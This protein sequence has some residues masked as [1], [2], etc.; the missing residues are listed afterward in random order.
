MLSP[1]KRIIHDWCNSNLTKCF[2]FYLVFILIFAVIYQYEY[3][4]NQGN[5]LFSGD[6]TN[7][8]NKT[9]AELKKKEIER[10][11]IKLKSLQ[12]LL[13]LLNK[14]DKK[15]IDNP[16]YLSGKK[17][18]YTFTEYPTNLRYPVPD[19]TLAIQDIH[20]NEVDTIHFFGHLPSLN[21]EPY[22]DRL[23]EYRDLIQSEIKT[24]QILI[25]EKKQ[26]IIFGIL[27]TSFISAS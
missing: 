10:A 25:S 19:S 4:I 22:P 6:I 20:G 5:F 2:L 24:Q 23:K 17:Y 13:D 14:K 12:I 1:F 26:I 9:F 7:R 15:I 27:L 21:F 18:K 3:N 16:F 8:Q 11:N